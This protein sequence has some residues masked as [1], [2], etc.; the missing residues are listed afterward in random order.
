MT[1]IFSG[2]K[3]DR[4]QHCYRPFADVLSIANW[5]CHHIEGTG[6]DCRLFHANNSRCVY[7]QK[8]GTGLLSLIRSGLD[9]NIRAGQLERP[10]TL[11]LLLS[12]IIC[13]SLSTEYHGAVSAAI[14]L[15]GMS[16][17]P[18]N[19]FRILV[20][21]LVVSSLLAGCG[22]TTEPTVVEPVVTTPTPGSID[23]LLALA[24]RSSEPAAS[25]YLITASERLLEEERI[26]AARDV[27][28]RVAPTDTLP[29]T[30]RVRLAAILAELSLLDSDATGALAWLE[31]DLTER[32]EQQRPALRRRV[33]EIRG[34]ALLASRQYQDAATTL[35]ELEELTPTI[36]GQQIGDLI[37]QAI[38]NLSEQ[39][40]TQLADNASSYELRGWVELARAMRIDQH[41]IASQIDSISRWQTVWNRHSAVQQ[42]P[43]QLQRL[44]EVWNSRPR[45]IAL[46]LPLREQI[47]RAVQE[48]FLSA[49]YQ[50]MEANTD[51]PLISVY[52]TSEISEIGG[53]YQTAV[54]SGAEL[55]IGPLDKELV[56]QLDNLAALPVPTLALNYTDFATRH[57]ESFFQF[58]LAPEDEIRQAASQAW[59]AGYRNAAIVAPDNIDYVRLQQAF[60]STW[61]SLGGNVVSTIRF[62]GEG[63]YADAIKQLL[64]IDASEERAARLEALLTRNT[65]EFVPSR[66]N[67]IDFIF[68]MA[69][70]RQGRQINP[71]LAFY[72]A[73]DIPV[74]ALSAINDGSNN[75]LAN[76]DLNGIIFTDSPWVLNQQDPLKVKV[77]ASLRN[78]Q[79]PLQRLRALGIDS[80][81]IYARL[82]QLASGELTNFN[83]VTGALT[84]NENGTIERVPLTAVFR[85]GTAIVVA[86]VEALAS[87]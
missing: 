33:A 9:T 24:E 45:H 1:S 19:C 71:T 51:V 57:A 63:E 4:L 28:S 27:V 8:I 85:N 5:S 65:I 29:F 36:E 23:A 38:Q 34:R 69:N 58:G 74:Y 54:E 16:S 32:L 53:I 41:S 80:F 56:R 62:S 82:E 86:N 31:S 35:I 30:L 78:T 73:G 81:R 15:P 39:Q 67:D 84:M 68:L 2:N 44:D 11:P 75:T 76:Q 50:A 10:I 52:D 70:P 7:V 66:R 20:V 13:I 79:G 87:N 17:I 46:L 48:G 26:A 49:Y 6:Q 21:Q 55:I 72:F 47:G 60:A 18:R 22:V 37:W 14:P 43:S 59:S 12:G 40:L 25:E 61:Q 64:S 83:G 42:L 3:I 77:S